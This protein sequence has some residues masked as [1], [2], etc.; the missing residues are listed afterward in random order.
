MAR[1][2]DPKLTRKALRRLRAARDRAQAGT[3]PAL[4]EWESEFLTSLEARLETY[5]SAFAD[6]A[7]GAPDAALSV[8]Q[9]AKMREIDRKSRGLDTARKGFSRRKPEPP[10][11]NRHNDEDQGSP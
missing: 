10:G 2:I 6:P 11:R 3:G 1:E 7:K 8:L 4:S 9:G 5:G